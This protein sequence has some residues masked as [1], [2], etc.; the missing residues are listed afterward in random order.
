MTPLCLTNTCLTLVVSSSNQVQKFDLRHATKKAHSPRFESGKIEI[1]E[2]SLSKKIYKKILPIFFDIGYTSVSMTFIPQVSCG[3]DKYH[4][5]VFL[6]FL[7]NISQPRSGR[8]SFFE[9]AD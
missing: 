5:R 4:F 9:I 6:E 8:F 7:Q 3:I 2:Q 1:A